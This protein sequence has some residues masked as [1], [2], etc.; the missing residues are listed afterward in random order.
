MKEV[1]ILKFL[2]DENI[3]KNRKPKKSKVD[4]FYNIISSLISEESKQIFYYKSHL[5]RYLVKEKGLNCS[6][7]TFN[8][9]ILKHENFTKYFKQRKKRDDVKSEGLFRKQVQFTDEFRV[10]IIPFIRVILNN[11]IKFESIMR[12]ID[13]IIIY[14]ALIDDEELFYEKIQKA[15]INL[16]QE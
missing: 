3:K 5:Y 16:I 15:I 7:S 12:I 10:Y 11:N 4:D 9:Y 14:N 13:E 1:I 8:A 6:M 2:S